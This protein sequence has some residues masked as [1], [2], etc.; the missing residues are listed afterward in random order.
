MNLVDRYTEVTLNREEP[1]QIY[2]VFQKTL[3][4]HITCYSSDSVSYCFISFER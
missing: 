2:P 4:V 3:I 1:P